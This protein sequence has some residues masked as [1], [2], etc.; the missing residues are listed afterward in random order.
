LDRTPAAVLFF[1]LL[2]LVLGC[3]PKIGRLILFMNHTCVRQLTECEYKHD[4]DAECHR[5][6]YFC[7]HCRLLP[8]MSS[9][10]NAATWQLTALQ[11]APELSFDFYEVL[12]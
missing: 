10:W 5:S 6:V 12:L 1:T 11:G 3:A 9:P 7:R 4:G 8:L 2:H